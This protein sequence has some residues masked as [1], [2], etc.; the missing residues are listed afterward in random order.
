MTRHFLQILS[1]FIVILL[2]VRCA[3]VVPL[4][5]GQRDTLPP[6]LLESSPQ[7]Y[8]TG[9]QEEVITFQFNEFVQVKN[10]NNQLIVTPR[11]KTTPEV[12][13]EGKKVKVKLKKEELAPNT[14]YRIYF[15]NAIA[16]MNE[17][18][19]LTNF[20]YVFSTGSYIDSLQVSGQIT[21]AFTNKTVSDVLVALY[22]NEQ[23][24][25]SLPYKTEPDFISR[26]DEN[27]N[28][29]LKN[30]P[31][32]T[33]QAYAFSDKNKNLLYDGEAEKIAFMPGE[34]KL[35]SDSSIH[36]RLF[37]E[38][39][40]K[41][42]IKK[43]ALP[44][45]G[46]VQIYLNKKSVVQVSTTNKTDAVNL[47]ETRKGAEKD[48]ITLYY[49]N[50]T[51]SLGLIVAYGNTNKSDTL[52]LSLPKSKTTKKRLQIASLNTNG[53]KLGLHDK[54]RLSFLTWMDT[55]RTDLNKIRFISKDDS[56]VAEKAVEAHWISINTCEFDYTFKQGSAY[57]LKADTGAFF[58]LSGLTNDSMRVNFTKQTQT[59][60]GKLTLK[61]LF[62]EK[63]NYVLQL[64]NEQDK[65]VKEEFVSLSLSS[66]N[67]ITLDFT[68]VAPGVYRAKIIFDQNKNKKWDSGSLLSKQQPEKVMIHSKQLK[69]I[70]DWEIE[71]EIVL[72]E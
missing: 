26:C 36:F 70:S 40:S 19:S 49:K 1:V 4:S 27:G 39:A 3:Q 20:E 11:L 69:I 17:S 23:A 67:S 9:F 68:D 59:E 72:K 44:Y 6:K 71:E 56:L 2:A 61:V 30:L 14:T 12:I 54:L 52:K 33:F 38:E 7:Q 57:T 5:G 53:N 16:D 13:A 28:F 37:Q 25:D 35:Q 55:A 60:F 18:N 66:S 43:T 15:G 58:D 10:L 31:Y 64:I 24:N 63:E 34:L 62:Y 65:V 48:T 45:Q 32:K 42:Y 21:D 41:L 29:I 50:I 51:D 46:L 8:T 47:S 22:Y